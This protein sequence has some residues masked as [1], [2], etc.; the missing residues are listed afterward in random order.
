MSGQP[1]N[2]HECACASDF[3]SVS[4]PAK[5]GGGF[6]L[7]GHGGHELDIIPAKHLAQHL[8]SGRCTELVEVED[9]QIWETPH[10][11]YASNLESGPQLLCMLL[12]G[13]YLVIQ[14]HP[15]MKGDIHRRTGARNLCGW[16]KLSKLTMS[17][18]GFAETNS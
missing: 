8:S 3:S 2:D 15:E 11:H 18:M 17:V 7:V 13:E 10:P 9:V 14:G 6:D 4:S 12:F 1:A 16:K 5:W